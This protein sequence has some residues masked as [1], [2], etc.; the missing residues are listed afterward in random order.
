MDIINSLTT[1]IPILNDGLTGTLNF[2]GSRREG[3][4]SWESDF[5]LMIT[6]ENQKV[7]W[8]LCQHLHYVNDSSIFQI[9]AFDN[10]NIPPGYCLLQELMSPNAN[11]YLNCLINGKVYKSSSKW[12]TFATLICP[13][14]WI[15]GPCVAT[16]MPDFVFDKVRCINS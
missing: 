11:H 7:I 9:F 2:S 10:S 15:H 6:F 12:T 4:R 14:V 5:D 3:F 13:N 16:N 8:N 1:R